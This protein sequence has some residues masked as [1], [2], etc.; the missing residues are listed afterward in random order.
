MK[1]PRN[2]TEDR[3]RSHS[4]TRR[5]HLAEQMG[6]ARKMYIMVNIRAHMSAC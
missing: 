5:A 2:Y 6:V 1:M 3:I 4:L